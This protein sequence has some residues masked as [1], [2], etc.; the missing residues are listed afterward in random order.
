[1][2]EKTMITALSEIL[3]HTVSNYYSKDGEYLNYVHGEFNFYSDDVKDIPKN[4]LETI[5]EELEKEHIW[6][7]KYPNHPLVGKVIDI[8]ALQKKILDLKPESIIEEEMY[9]GFKII[10]KFRM[11]ERGAFSF[12]HY[13]IDNQNKEFH[14]N[15]KKQC[16]ETID[17]YMKNKARMTKSPSKIHVMKFIGWYG[18][19]FKFISEEVLDEQLFDTSYEYGGTLESFVE[20]I[21]NKV[22]KE[23]IADYVWQE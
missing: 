20:E 7:R 3:Y 12:G 6:E 19:G 10:G 21:Q 13:F 17:H 5:L 2:M 16:K 4:A 9:N 22:K 14:C 8:P 18:G 11:W 1:M 23:K 15:G